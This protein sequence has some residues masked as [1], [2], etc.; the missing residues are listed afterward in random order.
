MKYTCLFAAS[1]LGIATLA[2]AQ[3][4]I[5]T[6]DVSQTYA[7]YCASCHGTNLEGG[8]GS[9]LVDGVWK[10]GGSDNEIAASI[11][12][13]YPDLGMVGWKDTLSENEIRSLVIFI[14]EKEK[15]ALAAPPPKPEPT[16]G[17]FTVAGERFRLEDVAE[18]FSILTL[19]E[20]SATSLSFSKFW[21]PIPT[22]ERCHC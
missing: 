13:G 1:A 5:G 15:Q 14:R 2:S 6:G 3:N 17:I 21:T 22:V 18:G 4:R 16:T 19:D 8:Q 10:Y 12:D 9:S 11:R 7:T 20:G